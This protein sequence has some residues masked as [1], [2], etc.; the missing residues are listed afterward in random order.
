MMKSLFLN[1]ALLTMVLPD[2]FGGWYEQS[3]I[4]DDSL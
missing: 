3:R 4:H 1:D 2:E